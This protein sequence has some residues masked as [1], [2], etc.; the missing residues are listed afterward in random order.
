MSAPIRTAFSGQPDAATILR[1]ARRILRR[2]CEPGAVL[3]VAP[4]MDKA[5]VLKGTVRTAVVDRAVAQA[6]ALKDWISVKIAGRVA[7]YEITSAGRAALKRILE[8]DQAREPGF[9]EARMPFAEVLTTASTDEKNDSTRTG[10]P[11]R[12]NSNA[13]D[14]FFSQS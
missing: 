6:F 14:I 3:A 13:A 2:L 9:A 4:D 8:D 12:V 5:V 10:L 11:F 7:T 1:E